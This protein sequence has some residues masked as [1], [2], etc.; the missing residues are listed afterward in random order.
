MFRLSLTLGAII[1]VGCAPA[2]KDEATKL[3]YSTSFAMGG[4]AA[5]RSIAM[6]TPLEKFVDQLLPKSFAAIPSGLVDSQDVAVTLS[7]AW[8]V[9][10]EIEFKA[11]ETTAEEVADELAEDINFHGPYFVDLTSAA[12]QVLDT[13][14]VS[15]KTIRRIEMKLEAAEDQASVNWPI[16]APAGL[17]N[18]SMY[19]EGTY[20]S[21]AFTFASHDGTEFKVSGAGGITPEEGQ[22][23]LMSIRFADIIRKINLSA[24]AVAVDKNISDSN[25]V[26]ATDP[27]PL[28]EAGISDLFTC[29]RKGL[30][31]EADIGK[32]SDGS[33]ELEVDED[34]ADN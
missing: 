28:I 32:D 13:Q 4:S 10:K 29:F 21:V 18:N 33:G 15:A 22:D 7:S 23:L 30:E 6:K 26:T 11:A 1:A 3:A 25:R 2:K 8:I 19:L 27:C 17:A 5:P 14:S 34:Q 12:P 16:N 31:Y 24:L 20:N 9:V